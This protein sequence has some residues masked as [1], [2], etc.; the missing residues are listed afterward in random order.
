MKDWP[1]EMPATKLAYMSSLMSV[2]A[3]RLA[4]KG[5]KSLA[6]RLRQE[7]SNIDTVVRCARPQNDETPAEAGEVGKG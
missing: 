5:H 4:A 2:A 3:A 1:C 6:R 7:V